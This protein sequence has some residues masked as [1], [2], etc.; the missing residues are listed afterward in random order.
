MGLLKFLLLSYPVAL[1]FELAATAGGDS[2]VFQSP[3]FPFN[4]LLWY[5]FMYSLLFF[6]SRDRKIWTG[7]VFF[8]IL[9]TLVEI[10]LFHRTGLQDPFT[11]AAMGFI[12]IWVSRKF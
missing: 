11:Y 7:V 1:V 3:L 4:F 6:F 12:P 2:T 9:G 5:G 8:S 10:F